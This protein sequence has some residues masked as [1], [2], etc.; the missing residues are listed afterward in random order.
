MNEPSQ[1]EIHVNPPNFILR[2]SHTIDSYIN[3][4]IIQF[5][6]FKQF[7]LIIFF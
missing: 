3:W 7:A 5:T 4:E 1:M 6:K 2:E